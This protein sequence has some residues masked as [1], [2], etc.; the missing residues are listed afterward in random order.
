MPEELGLDTSIPPSV[1]EDREGRDPDR[2]GRRRPRRKPREP[3]DAT[4]SQI[5]PE[6]PEGVG[7]RLDVVA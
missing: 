2:S 6:T 7:T 5:R 4:T 1:L 3:V